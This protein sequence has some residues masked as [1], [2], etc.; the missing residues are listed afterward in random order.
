MTKRDKPDEGTTALF[1]TLLLGP[2]VVWLIYQAI[3]GRYPHPAQRR[4]WP[5]AWAVIAFWGVVLYYMGVGPL[6][7]RFD[8]LTKK[9]VGRAFLLFSGVLAFY[10]AMVLIFGMT[11]TRYGSHPVPRVACVRYFLIALMSGI[12]GGVLNVWSRRKTE[13]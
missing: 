1:V 10:G 2:V 13:T 12:I 4:F 5:A 3:I 6:I 9:S 11:P 8:L 7:K